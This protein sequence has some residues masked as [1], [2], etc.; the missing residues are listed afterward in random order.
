MRH[1]KRNRG[2]IL[3]SGFRDPSHSKQGGYD[4]ITRYGDPVDTL[5]LSEIPFGKVSMKSKLIYLPLAIL[6]IITRIRRRKYPIT[7]LFYADVT[8]LKFIPYFKLKKHKTVASIHMDVDQRKF[9]KSFVWQLRKFDKIIVLSTCYAKRLKDKYGIDACFVPHGFN[10]PEFEKVEVRDKKG[11]TLDHN[12]I[13]ILTIGKMYRD[14]S[15]YE[16]VVRKFAGCSHICF[17]LVGAPND[18]KSA[19]HDLKNVRIYNRLDDNEFYSLMSEADYCFLPLSFATA[20][21]ALLESQYLRL[22]LILPEI[23]GV[24]DYA[25]PAPYNLFYKDEEQLV[26]MVSGIRKPEKTEELERYVSR[27]AWENIYKELDKI[28]EDLQNE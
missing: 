23:P 11:K 12:I 8:V 17:H 5:L 2:R 19:C 26:Q 16:R 9:S 18:I 24:T 10:R 6:D 1:Q 13:N 7:H 27:F 15:L 28:Y 4:W 3:F 22:P 14:F 21:N 20:N 25:A